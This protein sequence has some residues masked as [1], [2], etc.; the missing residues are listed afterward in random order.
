MV[1]HQQAGQPI[2]LKMNLH[3]LSFVTMIWFLRLIE[4]ERFITLDSTEIFGP[5]PT[6]F[7]SLT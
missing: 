7:P 2:A 4:L 3:H 5:C 6:K 1:A